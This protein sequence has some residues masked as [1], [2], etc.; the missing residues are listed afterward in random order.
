[1]KIFVSN[2]LG[3]FLRTA[4]AGV[5]GFLVAKGF[6]SMEASA[7]VTEN[8]VSTSLELIAGVIAY[9]FA[10]LTSLLNKKSS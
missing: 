10:Q 9:G 8:L 4:I 7:T 6:L 1:M 2:Y 3:S 5:A